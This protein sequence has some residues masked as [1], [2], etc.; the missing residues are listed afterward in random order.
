MAAG[1][2][3]NAPETTAATNTC[4]ACQIGRL[5]L[6]PVTYTHLYLGTLVCVPNTPAWQCDFCH[7][8]E[9]DSGAVQRIEALVG[10]SGPPPNRPRRAPRSA[11]QARSRFYHADS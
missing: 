7:A 4:P 1:E 8:I 2:N 5:H 3:V 9:Y 10:Q 11:P 6:H